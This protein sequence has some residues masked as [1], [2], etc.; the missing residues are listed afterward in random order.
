MVFFDLMLGNLPICQEEVNSPW[1]A[2]V[3][4]L[5]CVLNFFPPVAPIK[6]GHNAG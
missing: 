3:L 2:L 1:S 6:K 4:C 5:E